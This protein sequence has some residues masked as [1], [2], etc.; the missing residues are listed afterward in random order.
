VENK[1]YKNFTLSL[2]VIINVD[3]SKMSEEEI[4]KLTEKILDGLRVEHDSAEISVDIDP[5]STSLVEE[6]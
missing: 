3:V 2:E 1:N 4:L 6:E 5:Y